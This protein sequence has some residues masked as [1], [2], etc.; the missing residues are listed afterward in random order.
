MNKRNKTIDMHCHLPVSNK[1]PAEVIEKNLNFKT[2]LA[3]NIYLRIM[4]VSYKEDFEKLK[5][6][7]QKKLLEQTNASKIDNFVILGLDGVYDNSGGQIVSKSLFSTDNE[8]V[9]AFVKKSKK[10]LAG[11]SINPMRKDAMEQLDIAVEK[12]AVLLKQLPGV[13]LFNPADKKYLKYYEKVSEY[14][15]PVL[16][17]IGQEFALPGSQIEHDYHKIETLIPM[18]EAGCTVIMA[19]AG[20]FSWTNEK[21]AMKEVEDYLYKYPNLYIDISAMASIHRKIR[22]YSVLN[23]E[24]AMDRAVYGS[25]FPV[26]VQTRA[27]AKR[28]GWSEIK[29]LKKLK[30]KNLMDQNYEVNKAIGV[31]DEIF[32]RGYSIIN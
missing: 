30:K 31:P 21:S 13:Q 6:D 25:D 5:Q 11:P 3:L 27:F 23:S 1:I 20:G 14:R 22:L 28:L 18:L 8:E 26:M 12:G 32:S 2:K 15:L 24:I 7:I 9:Y 17:H 10:L 19:H 4:G 16:S 29:R